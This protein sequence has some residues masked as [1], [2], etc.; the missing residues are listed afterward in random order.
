M[1][2]I[3]R[4]ETTLAELE[5]NAGKLSNL[6]A[7]V[8]GINELID[9]CRVAN[10][11]TEKSQEQLDLLNNQLKEKIEEL[12]K[13]LTVEQETKDEL[14]NNIRSAL[15]ANTKEQ[16]DAVNSITSVV[17]NKIAVVESSISVKT[18]EIDNGIKQNNSKL[19]ENGT[20]LDS[21]SNDI[22]S[23]SVKISDYGDKLTGG[24]DEL[25]TVI[26]IIKRTQIISIVAAC[27]ALVACILSV[28]L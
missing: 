15:T 6:P 10:S 19:S 9:L 1:E 24:V 16:L 23:V 21:I 17:N 12:Q 4:L 2:Y 7:L 26:P 13:I 27:L 14:L 8:K 20:K 28:I 11:S 22:S 18:A 3:E 25:K 5:N